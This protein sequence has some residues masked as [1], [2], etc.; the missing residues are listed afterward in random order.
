MKL[1]L[2][3]QRACYQLLTLRSDY[4][5]N[6]HGTTDPMVLLNAVLNPA[7]QIIVGF[8]QEQNVFLNLVPF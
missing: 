3:Y 5:S 6:L 7:T 8:F 1:Y 4:Q 2:R